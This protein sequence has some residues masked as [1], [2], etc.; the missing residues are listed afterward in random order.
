MSDVVFDTTVVAIG[1]KAI[2]DRKPGNSFD[3]ILRLLQDV[4]DRLSHVR[5]NDKLRNEYE[6]HVKNFRNDVIEIFFSMLDSSQAIRVERNT[7]SRQHFELAVRQARWQSHDQ[8][9]IAAAL[10]GKKTHLYVTEQALEKCARE[11][12]RIFRIRVIK[13]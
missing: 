4:V 7:L 6:E 3:R 12:Y 2:A 8:H 5:Y 11:I 9:L 1:N 10:G 13:A